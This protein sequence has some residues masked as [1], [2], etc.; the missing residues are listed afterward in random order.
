M[1]EHGIPKQKDMSVLI[2]T[3]PPGAGNLGWVASVSFLQLS[4]VQPDKLTV[5]YDIH[6]AD[7]GVLLKYLVDNC[8]FV[9]IKKP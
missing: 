3:F 8:G 6:F 7:E 4:V 1:P 9:E 5:G 2:E